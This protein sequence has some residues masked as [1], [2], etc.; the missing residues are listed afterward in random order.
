MTNRTHEAAEIAKLAGQLSKAQ[1]RA[2]LAADTVW[3]SAKEMGASGS[4]LRSLCWVWPKGASYTSPPVCLLSRDYQDTPL[5]YIYRLTGLG[6]DVRAALRARA[7]LAE[8]SE[9]E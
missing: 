6:C 1:Q 5:R 4:S 7:T 3:L 8:R 9:S 2:L